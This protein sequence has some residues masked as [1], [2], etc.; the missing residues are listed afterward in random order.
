VIELLKAGARV[1]IFDANGNT[2]LWL[3]TDR[4]HLDVVKALLMPAEEVIQG[5][6]REH[7]EN[8]QGTYGLFRGTFGIFRGTFSPL[9]GEHFAYFGEH[10]AYFGE[11]LTSFGE[12]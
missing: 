3:A 6:F 12:H 5:T 11:H 4:G 10:N 7:S 2:A 1:D 9:L 8:I